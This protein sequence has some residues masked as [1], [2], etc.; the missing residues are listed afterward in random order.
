[1]MSQR[2]ASAFRCAVCVA[3]VLAVALV[4]RALPDSIHTITHDGTTINMDFVT[5]NNSGNA[6]DTR[7]GN[8]S[9]RG[10]VAYEFEFGEYHVTNAQY[11]Q[12][13]NAVAKTDTYG[14]Y[15]VYMN[16][17]DPGDPNQ[18]NHGGIERS[19][20]EGN[21]QY[22]AVAGREN[23]PVIYVSWFDAARFT[24]W[25]TTGDTEDGVYSTTTWNAMHRAT[26]LGTFG[27][28]Y[29]LPTYDEWYKAA[30]HNKNAG[31]GR[32]YFEYGTGSNTVP[33]QGTPPG[34]SNSANFGWL[35]G[36]A[37]RHPTDVGAYEDTIS[38]YGAYD[39]AG[40]VWDWTETTRTVGNELHRVRR[41]GS[42]SITGWGMEASV[43]HSNLPDLEGFTIGFRV[44]SIPEPGSVSL[45]ICAAIAG[46][47][48]RRRR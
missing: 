12:F 5:V 15:N 36:N 25:L 35:A 20:S 44:A 46:L 38:P 31:L 37:N 26:A 47:M 7:S 42:F 10:A 32:S 3:A 6:A 8:R 39:M 29:F 41:G 2:N 19:G 40:N 24:N 30:Y 1:M 9:G 33:T 45:L 22:A 18:L 27:V 21:W 13:L 28:A 11:A 14:L 48:R 43:L 23:W 16:Q 17:A 4:S 34:G